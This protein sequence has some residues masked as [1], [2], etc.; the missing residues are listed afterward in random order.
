MHESDRQLWK[1]WVGLLL[2]TVVALPF[3][4][5]QEE[6]VAQAFYFCVTMLSQS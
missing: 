6:F 5:R 3:L 1:L 2:I 4:V